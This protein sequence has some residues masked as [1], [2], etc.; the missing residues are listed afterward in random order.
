MLTGF[1]VLPAHEALK[2]DFTIPAVAYRII[3]RKIAANRRKEE[4]A[5]STP[6]FG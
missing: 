4:P 3:K 6:M 1:G 5:F 2:N